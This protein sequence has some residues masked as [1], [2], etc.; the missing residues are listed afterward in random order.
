MDLSD[1]PGGDRPE[2]HG[3]TPFR[4]YAGDEP[5]FPG[6]RLHME[7]PFVT[8]LDDGRF[9]T[10]VQNMAGKH[11]CAYPLLVCRCRRQKPP[12]GAAKAARKACLSCPW[13]LH[14]KLSTRS[15][16]RIAVPYARLLGWAKGTE[17][18]HAEWLNGTIEVHHGPDAV[19]DWQGKTLKDDSSLDK[20]FPMTAAEHREFHVQHG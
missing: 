3:R 4:E 10:R 15:G 16:R 5:G 20:L 12:A 13:Y 14:V 9:A 8:Q 19:L 1:F 18:T 11:Y 7:E 6:Y 2:Q 17:H